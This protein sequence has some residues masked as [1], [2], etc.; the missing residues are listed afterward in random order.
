MDIWGIGFRV[1][2]CWKGVVIGVVEIIWELGFKLSIGGEGVLV[3][4]CGGKLTGKVFSL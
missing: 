2:W 4:S 1:T 3:L